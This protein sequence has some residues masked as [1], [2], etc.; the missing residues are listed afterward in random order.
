MGSR[1][2]VQLPRIRPPGAFSTKTQT[3][4]SRILTIGKGQEEAAFKEANSTHLSSHVVV[5][6]E[7]G[8]R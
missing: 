3:R 1:C 7:S 5:K 6:Q 4:Q 8:G 2:H